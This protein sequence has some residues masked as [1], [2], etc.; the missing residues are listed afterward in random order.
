MTRPISNETLEPLGMR[1]PRAV[2]EFAAYGLRPAVD[3]PYLPLL[4]RDHACPKVLEWAFE[5]SIRLAPVFA[6][7]RS[8]DWL[9]VRLFRF[10]A[11]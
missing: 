5:F 4:S 7:G 2:F 10:S 11:S 3:I 6:S 1:R 8:V 9:T